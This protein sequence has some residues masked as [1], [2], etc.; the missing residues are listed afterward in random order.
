MKRSLAI[1]LVLV[2]TLTFIIS[3][4][5]LGREYVQYQE[6]YLI[7]EQLIEDVIQENTETKEFSI[8]WSN[9]KSINEDIVA[10]IRI[11]GTEINYPVLQDSDELFYL[12]H[13]FNKKYNNN[14]SIFTINDNPFED[15]ETVI[16]GHNMKNGSMFSNLTYYLDED[17]LHLHNIIEIYTPNKNYLAEIFSVYT[18]DIAS[19][20]KNIENLNFNERIEYYRKASSINIKDESGIDKIIKLSTGS[21]INAKRVPTEQ[22]CYAVAKVISTK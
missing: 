1:I 7:T 13:S 2:S 9:L 5:I 21:Y 3:S 22:R 6:N 11:M 14:G 18:I 16:Y 10:W 12:K 17:Y 19:E 8:D 20:T 15:I 4:C